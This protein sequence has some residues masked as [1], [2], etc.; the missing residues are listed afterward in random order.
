MINYFP[1]DANRAK[2]GRRSSS[3]AGVR[4]Q[5]R[6]GTLG[7]LRF[8]AAFAVLCF[9]WGWNG[10]QNGKVTTL[11]HLPGTSFLL[12][13]YFGVH[14]FFLISGYLIAA[15]ARGKT[16][17]DFAKTRAV[18]LFPAFWVALAITSV[19]A[20]FIGGPSMSVSPS[21][22]LAN[23]T[24][25]PGLFNVPAVDGVYWTLQYELTFYVAVLVVLLLRQGARLDMIIACWAILMLAVT[26]VFPSASELPLL[27]SFYSFF[28]GGAALNS[29][30]RRGWTVLSSVALASAFSAGLLSTLRALPVLSEARG[31]DSYDPVVVSTV[32]L[33]IYLLVL[34]VSSPQLAHIQLPGDRI[35][36]ELTYPLYLLHA[37]IGYMLINHFTVEQGRWL[38][39]VLCFAAVAA[40]SYAV[41]RVVEVAWAPFWNATFDRLLGRPL[42]RISEIVTFRN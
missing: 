29:I 15:T 42:N 39:Y 23:A 8:L 22:I 11:D 1:R 41:H 3:S 31:G 25:V 36:G 32:L 24:M 2:E 7:Y 13:G 16:P 17:G 5:I 4:G 19:V 21:Q 26:L 18:R 38:V 20:S 6:I 12:Y 33:A 28:A 37:H 14:L 27:G 9:H 10:I 35:L 30:R 34:L 40:L